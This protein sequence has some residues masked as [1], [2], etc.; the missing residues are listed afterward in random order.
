MDHLLLPKGKGHIRVPNL[1]YGDY[2]S[3]HGSFDGYPARCGWKEEHIEGKD[4]FGGRSETEIAAFFQSWLYFGC[5]IEVLAISGV[6][7]Q[8]SDLL[9]EDRL[10]VCTHKLPFLLRQW[11]YRMGKIANKNHPTQIRWA[12][13]T[14]LILRK[15]S[16]FV[17]AYCLPYHGPRITSTTQRSRNTTSPLPEKVWMSIIALGQTLGEATVRFYD[18]RST[19]NHW[20]ASPMLKRRMLSKGW[21][22]MDVE[23][24]LTDLGIDGCYYL[25]KLENLD[26]A[27]SHG[28]CS[29]DQCVAGNIDEDTY[30]QKHLRDESDCEG[31]KAVDIGRL[32]EIVDQGAI[33]VIHWDIATKKLE[34]TSS[35][36][37]RRGVSNPP[38][39]ALSHVYVSK[40]P[41]G[42]PLSALFWRADFCQV[43]RRYG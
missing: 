35:H 6:T 3:G 30:Q 14:A 24:S 40:Y 27:R 43:E 7:V 32:M 42:H 18:I 12:M 15:V 25:S 21:C 10:F 5:A 28:Q 23:R 9:D 20:G 31:M 36:T 41:Q 39:I 8:Q 22:P 29:Q 37:T 17:D 11:K 34:I 2:T 4:S 33:P 26:D 13:K 1:T 16:D 19:G 38:Y